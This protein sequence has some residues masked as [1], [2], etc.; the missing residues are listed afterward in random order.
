MS[1]ALAP[2]T[3]VRLTS[4]ATT[5]RT[6][7]AGPRTPSCPLAGSSSTSATTTPRFDCVTMGNHVCGAGAK[8]AGDRHFDGN[9][10]DPPMSTEQPTASVP[11]SPGR[12]P[13]PSVVSV[14]AAAVL[15]AGAVLV[16]T[17]VFQAR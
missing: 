15:I 10:R 11:A 13:T 17:G 12:G 14:L 2:T 5:H 6:T 9:R 4:A 8:G 7:S 1:E 3:C 16:G